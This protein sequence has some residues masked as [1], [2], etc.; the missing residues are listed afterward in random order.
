MG[1]LGRLKSGKSEEE[2]RAEIKAIDDEHQASLLAAL[3]E[4]IAE[5]GRN[6]PKNE[7]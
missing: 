1:I 2:I 3:D 7:G 4:V 5:K 6:S